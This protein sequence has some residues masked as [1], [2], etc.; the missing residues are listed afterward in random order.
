MNTVDLHQ[1]QRDSLCTDSTRSFSLTNTE[2]F[3][4][5]LSNMEELTKHYDS[6]NITP[7]KFKPQNLLL[8]FQVDH[9]ACLSS[10][11]SIIGTYNN[12]QEAMYES[13]MLFW[14]SNYVETRLGLQGDRAR[15]A[16]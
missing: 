10:C 6:Y 8:I 15:A 1:R 12:T 11:R 7:H 3:K 13:S 4:Q 16:M 5:S 14:D 2:R 9:T